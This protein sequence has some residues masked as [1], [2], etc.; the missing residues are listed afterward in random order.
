MGT[1]STGLAH[2]EAAYRPVFRRLQAYPAAHQLR[3]APD[4]D[5]CTGRG[6]GWRADC[7]GD[8]GRPGRNFA[9]MLDRYPQFIAE[10]NLQDVWQHGPVSLESCGTPGSWFQGKYDLQYIFNQALRWHVSTVNIKSTAIPEEWKKP[11][12][13]F[14][15]KAGTPVCAAQTGNP[16]S[17]E[18]L[19]RVSEEG[20]L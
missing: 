20:G 3:R 11:F 5:L 7:W 6:A 1:L 18:T 13:E 17:S 4:A 10:G 19:R 8:M 12:E 16:P 15:K 14:Q 2:P 9:Y